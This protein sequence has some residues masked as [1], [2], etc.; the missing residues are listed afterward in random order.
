MLIPSSQGPLNRFLLLHP[1]RTESRWIS[2]PAGMATHSQR[3]MS[4]TVPKS[5]QLWKQARRKVRLDNG[6]NGRNGRGQEQ[7]T[8]TATTQRA[9]ETEESEVFRN[10]TRPQIQQLQ[11]V[12]AVAMRPAACRTVKSSNMGRKT[13]CE[14]TVGDC[15]LWG[16]RREGQD[17]VQQ[18]DR[19]IT[20][21]S[22]PSHLAQLKQNDAANF[23]LQ[24]LLT[25]HV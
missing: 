20:V 25:R 11:A 21:I 1:E 6:S 4:Q 16:S 9:T 14:A 19:A 13:V 23:R 5:W 2:H 24:R 15:T 12:A 17:I 22:E 10:E 3:R 7:G 18:Q 8:R